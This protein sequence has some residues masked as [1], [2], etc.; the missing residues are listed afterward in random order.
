MGP[1]HTTGVLPWVNIAMEMT[2]TSCA[3]GGRIIEST[4]VGRSTTPIIRGTE[5]P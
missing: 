2:F 5:W 3:I 1:R 4:W